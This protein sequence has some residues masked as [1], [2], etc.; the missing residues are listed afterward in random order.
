MSTLSLTM[1]DK[2]ENSML[3]APQESIFIQTELET[4]QRTALEIKQ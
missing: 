4:E 3:E 1:L 2:K